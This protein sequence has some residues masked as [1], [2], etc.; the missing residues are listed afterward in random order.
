MEETIN[1][2]EEPKYTMRWLGLQ[3]LFVLGMSFI[4]ALVA[5]LVDSLALGRQTGGLLSGTNYQFVSQSI[6]YCFAVTAIT[7]ISLSLIEVA[8]KKG[9][10]LLQ[11][12]LIGCALCLFNLLLL[13]MSEQMPFWLA[14]VVVSVMT[15]ALIGWFVTQLIQ[16]KKATFLT[17]TI[18]TVEYGLILTLIY[19]GSMA[20]LI[21]SL[22][23]FALLATAMY[24]TLKLK[25]ENEELVLK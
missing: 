17:A 20:L 11:Y 15:I 18:L 14:Y 10:N 21:G 7:S 25:V 6:A 4:L 8:F 16:N 3:T 23:L 19:L 12:C 9:A 13:A 2:I 5:T 22:V 1:T 24:F